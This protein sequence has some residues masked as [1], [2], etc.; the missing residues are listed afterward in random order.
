MNSKDLLEVE[1]NTKGIILACPLRDILSM[2]NDSRLFKAG[3]GKH[4]A[5][6]EKCPEFL[7]SE[8]GK[9]FL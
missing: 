8:L 6:G 9:N 4:Q 5:E 2:T 7:E 1:G 3:N